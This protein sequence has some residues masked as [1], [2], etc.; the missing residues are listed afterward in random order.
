L[1]TIEKEFAIEREMAENDSTSIGEEIEVDW[2]S[3]ESYQPP[4]AIIEVK[5]FYRTYTYNRN[6]G[7]VTYHDIPHR[8]WR[9]FKYRMLQ[10]DGAWKVDETLEF[11]D[12]SG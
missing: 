10:E 6:T 4:E 8:Y 3:V 9:I 11:V 5:Y 1:E 12:W 7:E 2:V